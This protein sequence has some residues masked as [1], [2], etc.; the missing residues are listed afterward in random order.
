M[1]Q[2]LNIKEYS[3]L[4]FL[5]RKY[6]FTPPCIFEEQKNW[7]PE[8][9]IK[10]LQIVV[11]LEINYPKL[12]LWRCVGLF[13]PLDIICSI[14]IKFIKMIMIKVALLYLCFPMKKNEKNSVYFWLRKMTLKV[15]IVLFSTF[16]SKTTKRPNIFLWPLVIW[17]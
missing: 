14:F 3:I 13:N 11:K 2:Q 17:S 8:A 1:A 10:M 7:P 12:S 9:V 15:R 6:M 4:E 5:V 16:N